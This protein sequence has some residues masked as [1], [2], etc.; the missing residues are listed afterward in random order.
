MAWATL[1]CSSL[2]A[3]NNVLTVSPA[4]RLKIK[5]NET[6]VANV[7]VQLR[8]GYHVN[9]NTPSDEYLIPL[10][11]TW[12]AA[13]LEAVDVDYPKPKLEKYQFSAKPLSVFS[14]DF[15]IET[16]FKAPSNATNGMALL[17]GK[18]RYQACTDR[19]CLPPKTANVTLTADIQ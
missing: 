15:D 19:M 2:L 4:G 5:R 12:D 8:T 10:K 13:P 18:L 6:A 17:S 16:K 11:L 1:L 7:H 3:Q 9:S 14:G